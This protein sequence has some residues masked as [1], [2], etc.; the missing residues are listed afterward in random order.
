MRAI[1]V[2]RSPGGGG[3]EVGDGQPAGRRAGHA[4]D[5]VR[6]ERRRAELRVQAGRDREVER[7]R[8]LD[9]DLVAGLEADRRWIEVAREE[10]LEPGLAA[11]DAVVALAE[12]RRAAGRDADVR[13]LV[14]ALRED[15]L[16]VPVDALD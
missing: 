15:R 1:F 10:R 8:A 14:V 4:A 3:W 7:R 16:D 6:D 2:M 13:A 11:D 5:G 9:P 12:A